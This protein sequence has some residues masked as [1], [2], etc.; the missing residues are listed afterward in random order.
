MQRS[1]RER[2]VERHYGSSG[3]VERILTAWA[4]MGKDVNALTPGDLA[5]VDEFHVRG[6]QA[7]IELAARLGLSAENRVLDIGC[8]LG[9]ASRFLATTYGCH[10]TGIDVTP[11]Y[12]EG[13]RA[14]AER[15][16][17][18][19]RVSYHQAS[20]LDLPFHAESF[21]VVWTQHVVMNISDRGRFYSEV[22]RVLRPGGRF[23]MYD[24]VA[25]SAGDV[26][27]PVPWAREA[28]ISHLLGPA[29]THVALE[30]S[31]LRVL[32]WRDTSA[33]GRAWF[34]EMNPKRLTASVPLGL[35]LLLGDDFPVM[36][37][38]MVRNL[39]EGRIALVEAV[40][41]TSALSLEP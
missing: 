34:R 32:S 30:E 10:V 12:C 26:H 25:G 22:R 19:D 27:L 23:A 28:S 20:A 13:A 1:D 7:T 14:L 4:A 8:G 31:G 17:L 5:P 21:D 37:R 41:S 39:D 11:E 18:G 15:L 3:L 24:V 16:E 36:A 40:A 29:A 6:R 35:H 2:A 33:L 9:G 38:N